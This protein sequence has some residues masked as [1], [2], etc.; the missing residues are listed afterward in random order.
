M[1][2]D[3]NT[4]DLFKQMVKCMTGESPWR[5]EDKGCWCNN[6]REIPGK[7]NP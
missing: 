3:N 2:F 7:I 6:Y 4:G 1:I 5:Y